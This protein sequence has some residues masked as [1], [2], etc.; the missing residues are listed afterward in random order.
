MEWALRGH[1]ETEGGDRVSLLELDGSWAVCWSYGYP[2]NG[3]QLV[4]YEPAA[5]V[6]A[7]V[8]SREGKSLVFDSRN[9]WQDG[10]L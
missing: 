7:F 9:A 4:P 1:Y 5:A 10:S 2:H 3:T 8:L 6:D